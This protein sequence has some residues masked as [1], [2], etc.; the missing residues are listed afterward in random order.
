MLMV[1]IC[2]IF[3][4]VTII[5]II[6]HLIVITKIGVSMPH[7]MTRGQSVMMI[8][9]IGIGSMIGRIIIGQASRGM[10]ILMIIL[11]RIMQVIPF[12]HHTAGSTANITRVTRR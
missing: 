3:M 2:V 8:R 6:I 1:A 11:I 5:I 12:L 4:M 10:L 7:T 9:M